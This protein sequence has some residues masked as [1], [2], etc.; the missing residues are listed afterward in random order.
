MGI[1]LTHLLKDRRR[2]RD[3]DKRDLRRSVDRYLAKLEKT[4]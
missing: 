3:R 4:L 2:Q 1:T